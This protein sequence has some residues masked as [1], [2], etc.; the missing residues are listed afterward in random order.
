M[1]FKEREGQSNLSREK[2]R[3]N[4]A[5]EKAMKLRLLGR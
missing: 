3:Q 1:G 5:I 2:L 4:R